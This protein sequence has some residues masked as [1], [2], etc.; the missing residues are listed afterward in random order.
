MW[1]IRRGFPVV[2]SRVELGGWCDRR[3]GIPALDEVVL[4][5]VLVVVRK[6]VFGGGVPG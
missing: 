2:G 1:Q 4:D 6:S 5:E 3:R